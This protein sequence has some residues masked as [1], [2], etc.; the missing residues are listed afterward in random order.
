MKIATVPEGADPIQQAVN[1][2]PLPPKA[3]ASA[4]GVSLA[5]VYAMRR[6]GAPFWGRLSTVAA[7]LEWWKQNPKFRYGGTKAEK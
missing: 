2:V 4:M 7:L 3:L 1:Q 6:A 5:Y